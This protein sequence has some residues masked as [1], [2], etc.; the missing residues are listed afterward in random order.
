MHDF[1]ET[2]LLLF[3]TFN[4]GG[5]TDGVTP[6]PPSRSTEHDDLHPSS[7]ASLGL[8]IADKT[9]TKRSK[10]TSDS[11]HN[12][13]HFLTHDAIVVSLENKYSITITA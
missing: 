10:S 1:S 9:G 11:P 6:S 13:I 12:E 2:R 8:N 7:A 3:P 4:F 5:V